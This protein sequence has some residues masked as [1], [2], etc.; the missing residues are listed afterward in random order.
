MLGLD[1]GRPQP[2]GGGC[3][4]IIKRGGR[5][6]VGRAFQLGRVE[7]DPRDVEGP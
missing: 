7:N 5:V 1:I 2:L 3:D 4:P 6:P